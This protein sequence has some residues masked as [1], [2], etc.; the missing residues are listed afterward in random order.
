MPDDDRSEGAAVPALNLAD[1]RLLGTR[2]VRERLEQRVPGGGYVVPDT[3]LIRAIRAFDQSGETQ[4]RDTLFTM[5]LDRCKPMFRKMA[6]GLAHRP[7]WREDAISDMTVQLWREVLDPR[8]TFMLQ[9]FAHY[10]K[11]LCTDNFNRLL[12]AEGYG[13][14][15]NEQGQVTGR[16]EHVPAT[17]VD[18]IDRAA[19]AGDQQE[20]V[21][22]ILA[23]PLNTLD[24]RLAV[25]EAER[26]LQTLPD[27]LDRKIV[28]LRVFGN[29][30][31]EEIAALCGKTERTMRTRFER[32]RQ[33]M[34]STLTASPDRPT[35]DQDAAAPPRRPGARAK[36]TKS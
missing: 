5:L 25:L 34:Q 1:F 13:F 11:C 16:P 33:Q 29:L 36:G 32:A 19:P 12:R 17:L 23:D 18:T 22:D 30:Q 8:E 27:P 4:Q 2:G 9:N 6:N 28:Y 7:E 3:Q 15:T 26:I 31:W 24:A 35:T 21:V 20:A 10:L 14:R